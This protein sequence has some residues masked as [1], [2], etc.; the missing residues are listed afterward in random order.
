MC[1]VCA[2]IVPCALLRLGNFQPL[3]LSTFIGKRSALGLG[4]PLQLIGR[5]SVIYDYQLPIFSFHA[6]GDGYSI[7]LYRPS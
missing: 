4:S 6:R 2:G 5:L 3:N 1:I 7:F